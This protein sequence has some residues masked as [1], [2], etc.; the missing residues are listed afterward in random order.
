VLDDTAGHP[1][2]FDA[3]FE[4]ADL[5]PARNIVVAYA[6]RGSRG[7][8]IN[9]R[10]ALSLA[11]HAAALGAHRT[12]V[13]EAAETVGPLDRV[14]SDEREAARRGFH[15]RGMSPSWHETMQGAM[16]EAA[17]ETAPGDLIVLVGAQ[18]MNAGRAELERALA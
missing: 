10:N 7:P 1:E 4:V 2:S 16:Q 14:T 3:T 17:R 13:T 8:D 9:R 11:E 6:L 18:G 15:E 12:I 5:L